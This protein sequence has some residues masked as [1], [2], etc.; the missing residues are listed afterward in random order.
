MLESYIDQSIQKAIGVS[1][2]GGIAML[3]FGTLF[4]HDE[5]E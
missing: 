4:F 3:T 5:V 1:I 2:V